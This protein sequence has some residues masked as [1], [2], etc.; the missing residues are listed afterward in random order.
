MWSKA[1]A[2]MLMPMMMSG[3]ITAAKL[4]SEIGDASKS[5]V[6]IITP[7]SCPGQSNAVMWTVESNTGP[8]DDEMY[9][10][11]GRALLLSNVDHSA[12][13]VAQ[14]AM[15]SFEE[16]K[17]LS[18]E[19]AP[20]GLDWSPLVTVAPYVDVVAAHHADKILT[21]SPL[22][23]LATQFQSAGEESGPV[24]V[25]KDDWTALLS[26][27]SR[28][29]AENGWAAS[30]TREL[31]R[32]AYGLRGKGR[33][34]LSESDR[35]VLATKLLIALYMEAY[36]RNGNIIKLDF[37]S[38]DLKDKLI[39]KLK[40]YKV[41]A[42]VIA[43]STD[44]I[45][46]LSSQYLGEL[47]KNVKASDGTCTLLGVIGEQTFVS[48]SGKSYGFPGVT[49]TIDLF[50]GRKVSTNKI[51]ANDTVTD[52]IRVL[53]EA[54]GDSA[55]GVPGVANSTYCKEAN[56]CATEKQGDIIKSV[57][58]AG[59]KAESASLGAIGVAIRGGWLISL[60]NDLLA[61]SISTA[62][63]VTA[64]KLAEG[65]TWSVL[66]HCPA[67]LNEKA[68]KYRSFTLQLRQ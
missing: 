66:Q 49:G 56:Q 12:M 20:L 25:T 47:C 13:P 14:G 11:L 61:D 62:G 18:A 24:V 63:A 51:S 55:F 53:I 37:N 34:Q 15:V 8:G 32:V 41:P 40:K 9:M 1:T 65:A 59:D 31:G 33:A 4:N 58:N 27:V 64:R 60:N 67:V 23:K 21:D 26:E 54:M 29:T 6:D 50:A 28:S 36:F 22:T 38:P 52:V 39:A 16:A 3:C 57:D 19:L 46:D 42:A 30:F 45:N 68:S 43:A 2:A 5:G 44:E 17:Q 35:R 7:I 10:E 48:R